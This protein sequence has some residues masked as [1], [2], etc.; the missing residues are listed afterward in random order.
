MRRIRPDGPERA[1]RKNAEKR[2]WLP[3]ELNKTGRIARVSEIGNRARRMHFDCISCSCE[4]R[5]TIRAIAKLRQ[6]VHQFL[7]LVLQGTIFLIIAVVPI[8]GKARRPTLCLRQAVSVPSGTEKGG[9]L[10]DRLSK[11][12]LSRCDQAK[13]TAVLRRRIEAPTSA[14]P[15]II[16]AHVAGSGTAPDVT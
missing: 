5:R 6:A 14:K 3:R 12:A 1:R 4:D 8:A 16:M 15:P 7:R 2:E 13:L 11:V 9:P 10:P